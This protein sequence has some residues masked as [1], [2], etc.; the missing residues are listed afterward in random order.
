MVTPNNLKRE[1]SSKFA[2]VVNEYSWQNV[3]K[4]VEAILEKCT[5]TDWDGVSNKL[6]KFMQWEFE[7][8]RP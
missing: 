6:S 8:Y 1:Y 3:I 5:D 4:S 2:I 7:D